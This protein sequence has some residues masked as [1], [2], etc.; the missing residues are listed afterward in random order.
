M[1]KGDRVICIS[2][3][4]YPENFRR[5]YGYSPPKIGDEGT[6]VYVEGNHLTLAEWPLSGSDTWKTS[7]WKKPDS[8]S[9]AI[10]TEAS[11][12]LVKTL[13][14]EKIGTQKDK[15]LEEERELI[16]DAEI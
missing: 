4:K 9:D 1:K 14:V 5:L 13:H 15:Y 10:S 8:H 3:E 12:S 16:L 6:V 2:L 11:R 7:G